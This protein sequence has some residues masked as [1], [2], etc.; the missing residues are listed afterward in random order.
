M[1]SRDALVASRL[2]TIYVPELIAPRR[3]IAGRSFDFDLALSDLLN[4]PARD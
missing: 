3:A 1:G 4:D 2:V